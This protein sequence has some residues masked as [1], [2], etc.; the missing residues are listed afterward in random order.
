MLF[1]IGFQSCSDDDSDDDPQTPEVE[2]FEDADGDGF[3]NPNV[4]VFATAQPVGFV[5]NDDDCD[6]TDPNVFEIT[7]FY[8]DADGDGLG[9]PDVSMQS[10]GQPNGFVAN[11]NDDDDNDDGSAPTFTIW[12]GD[13]ITFTKEDNADF[14][15]ADNQDQITNNISITRENDGGS[16]FN[17]STESS[18]N[19]TTSPEGTEWAFGT[20]DNIASLSFEPFVTLTQGSQGNFVGND[21]V[22]H[23]IELDVYAA[24]TF[25]A[26]TVGRNSGGG[27]SYTRSTP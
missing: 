22:V 2:F 14:N 26:W 5:D 8:Q 15:M 12:E 19:R 23:L 7:T 27:F 16:L 20:T 25:D 24:V 3:G 6:D 17:I 1:A 21:M 9:N 4:S 11:S 10:C 13:P 18:S